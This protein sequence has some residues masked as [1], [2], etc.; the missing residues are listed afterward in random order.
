MIVNDDPSQ[1]MMLKFIL[2]KAAKSAENQMTLANDGVEAVEK[3]ETNFFHIIL[4]DCNMPNMDG[5]EPSLKIKSRKALILPYILALS[6][7][8]YSKVKQKGKT[9]KINLCVLTPISKQWFR[10][11]VLRP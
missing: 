3:S 2:T 4:K 9:H 5:Y 8:V 7:H 6:A 1:Q 11:E 10:V